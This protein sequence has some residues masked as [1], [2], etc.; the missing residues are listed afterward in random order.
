MRPAKAKNAPGGIMKSNKGDDVSEIK[1]YPNIDPLP[2]T[3]LTIPK[4]VRPIVKPIP[5]PTASNIDCH[6]LFLEAKASARP[7]IIQL[8]TINGIK[9]PNAPCKLGKYAAISNSITVTMEAITT[10]YEGIRIIGGI[11]FFIRDIIELEKI[12]TKRVANPIPK[13]LFAE[14]VTP[15]V[16]HIPKSITKVGFSFIIPLVKLI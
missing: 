7:K 11:K 3:S 12:K 2:K 14:V 9:M 4:D 16:G 10:I 6:I 13:P 8:T 15:K 5:I 1:E